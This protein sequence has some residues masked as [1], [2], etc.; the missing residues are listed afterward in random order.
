MKP[1]TRSSQD[2]IQS[3]AAFA[4][5]LFIF[6]HLLTSLVEATYSFGLLSVD[7][8]PEVVFVLFLLAPLLLL[9]YP[10]VLDGKTGLVFT[11]VTSGLAMICWF[12][13]LMQDTRWKMI[14]CGLGVGA[15]LL[16]L[17][18]LLRHA[19]VP[20]ALP[21][22]FGAMLA[23][24]ALVSIALRSIN[25]G[26][27]IFLYPDF[28]LVLLAGFIA[29]EAVGLNRWI[30]DEPPP[31]GQEGANQ[32]VVNRLGFWRTGL[33]CLGLFSALA[34]V[35]TAFFAPAVIARWT[36]GSYPWITALAAAP[37]LL[38][39]AA[40]PFL[41]RL[42][43][44]RIVLAWNLLFAITLA[45]AIS[46]Y[47]VSFP[48]CVEGFPF[49]QTAP[50]LPGQVAVFAMML[51]HPV[52]YLDFGLL[53]KNL[54]KPS[55]PTL[56][57]GFAIG[58][59]YLALLIFAQ[60][61]TTVYDY[62]PVVGP[63]FRDR[64]ALV[65]AFPAFVLAL[66]SFAVKREK[67][68]F[69]PAYRRWGWGFLL[70]LLVVSSILALGLAPAR[71]A[72]ALEKNTV[73][74]LTYNIQQGYNSS[75][76]KSFDQQLE[77]LRSQNP[78]IIGLQETDTARIA[79]GNSDVVRYFTERLHMYSYYGP[80]T[81]T[82]TFGIALLSRF[83]IQ[84]AR[85]FFMYSE[86]E[87]TAAIQARIVVNGKPF[88]VLVTHLGNGGPLI[89]QQQVLQRLAGQQNIIAMGDFNFRSD[90]E[91]YR[92]TIT[93]LQDGWLASEQQQVP[94][95]EDATRRIDHIFLSPGTRVRSAT[96]LPEG[97][98]DHPGM[99]IEIFWD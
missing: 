80:R 30:P 28:F 85:T 42:L 67:A 27:D 56:A 65:T 33:V 1:S 31:E 22:P 51:L 54:G 78:D 73:R 23:V 96:Y 40:W 24:A 52:I 21:L 59:V 90:T 12:A 32:P 45:L 34:L 55:L 4:A 94:E 60:V 75:G 72:P 8:P 3:I 57:G 58:A 93:T 18:G 10:R 63:W 88:T 14:L 81:T 48:C 87:Q 64:F 91:A 50:G 99:V 47:S 7:I 71:F 62:I 37:L 9:I 5:F 38:L 19:R 29:L 95:G 17:P 20:A 36:E 86:G 41:E 61:F 44:P 74:V 69:L 89:Q 70:G 11:R 15:A 97:P 83:P 6:L 2:P 92:Q 77:V 46:L 43:T 16:A 84:D 25:S 49:D 68:E 82:G 53:V 98:S 35:Y 13:G 79:G 76:R 26:N 39:L 66:S